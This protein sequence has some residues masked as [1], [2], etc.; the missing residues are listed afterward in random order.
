MHPGIGAATPAVSVGSAQPLPV[1][2]SENVGP[3]NVGAGLVSV[4][5][6]NK[7]GL[8]PLTLEIAGGGYWERDARAVA[9]I[10]PAP[11]P[12]VCQGW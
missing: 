7:D 6:G 9:E 8:A 1:V 2:T 5:I 4:Y 3:G 10:V 11:G 12:P